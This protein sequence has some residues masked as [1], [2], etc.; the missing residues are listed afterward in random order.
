[1]ANGNI[2]SADLTWLLIKNN[3]SFMHKRVGAYRVFSA[4]KGN[5]RNIHAHKFSGLANAR[6]LTIE[7]TAS[8][9]G[10][11]IS[12]RKADASPFAI[13]SAVETKKVK[14]K[15]GRKAA[16]EV[17]NV[18]S[19]KAGRLD[20]RTDALARASAIL[21]SQS[22]RKA[23]RQRSARGKAVADVPELSEE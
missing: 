19:G 18:A 16:R 5:L 10:L 15:S 17:M 1:M 13:A 23:Q 9:H 11:V 4:E 7:G 12:N 14:G 8:N 3:T 6:T 20:L 22:S 21:A 2:A